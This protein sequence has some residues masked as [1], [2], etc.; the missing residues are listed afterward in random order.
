MCVYIYMLCY[1]MLCHVNNIQKIMERDFGDI[2]STTL[3]HCLI[4]SES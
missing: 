3:I 2:E 1:V 4:S